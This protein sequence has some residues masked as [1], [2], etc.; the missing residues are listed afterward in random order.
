MKQTRT[1]ALAVAVLALAAIVPIAR[2]ATLVDEKFDYPNG[3]LAGR[4]GWTAHS[5]LG[6]QAVQVLDYAAR[7]VQGA[8]TAEDVNVAFAPQAPSA[9]T[10][11]GFTLRVPSLGGT[12]TLPTPDYF[13]HFRT[14]SNFNFRGRVHLAAAGPGQYSVGISVT[15][16]GTSPVVYW[17]APLD[18]DEHYRIVVSYSASAGAATLSVDPTSLASPSVAS[19]HPT[20]VGE[21]VDSYALR[22]SNLQTVHEHVDDLVVGTTFDDVARPCGSN[23]VRP[24]CVELRQ[25][26]WVG[27]TGTPI[28][29]NSVWG[30]LS[31]EHTP[32]SN[33][34]RYANLVLKRGVTTAWAIQNLPLFPLAAGA[35]PTRVEMA[36][37]DLGEIGVSSGIGAGPV[38]YLLTYDGGPRPTIP[39][40]PFLLGSFVPALRDAW[41]QDEEAIFPGPWVDPGAPE[42]VKGPGA[43]VPA[44]QAANQ[45]RDVRPVQ[46]A[47]DHCFAGATARSL[48]WLNR[49]YN[50]GIP[51]TAQEIYDDLVAAGVSQPGL[52]PQKGRSREEWIK[53]KDTYARSQTNNGIV[54]GAWDGGENLNAIPNVEESKEKFVDWLKRELKAGEDVELTYN[55]NGGAHIVTVLEVYEKDG[56]LYV[57]Y[58]DDEEQG[59][60]DEKKK[61]GDKEVKHAKLVKKAGGKYGFRTDDNTITW[62]LAESPVRKTDGVKDLGHACGAAQAVQTDFGNSTLGA[63]DFANGSELDGACSSYQENTLHLFFAGNLESNFNKLEVFIDCVGGGQ[64]RLRNDNPNVDFDGL[65]R[66]GDDGSGNGLRFD[67]GFEADYWL[68]VTGGDVGGGTYRMFANY[69]ELLTGGGGT[70]GYLGETIA[71]GDGTLSGGS[72]PHGIKVAIVNSNVGGVGVGCSG[73]TAGDVQTG[74][75]FAIPLSALGGPFHCA[76]VTAFVNGG[77]HDFVSNQVLASLP[78]GTCNLGEPRAVD[79]ATVAGDQYFTACT[80][81]V[82]VAADPGRAITATFEAFPNPSRGDVRFAL[83]LRRGEAATVGIYDVAGRL[84]RRLDVPPVEGPV[85]PVWDGRDFSGRRV[86]PGLYL[87]RVRAD[88]VDRTARVL[89]L[90]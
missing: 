57:T 11:A 84:V 61:A 66:M 64:N 29:A 46:E 86:P 9:T 62:G 90:R 60:T 78:P 1:T 4:P 13:A 36:D 73:S 85:A 76:R 77:A 68:S 8:S 69:A 35:G 53:R 51:R 50:L 65:N 22:Q 79:L 87:A 63:V 3:P 88:G 30:A 10:W 25:L 42:A 14:S 39:V 41:D 37:I 15:S 52:N 67:E 28:V 89:R 31:F 56:E 2:A 40:G 47:E 80:P 58:R 70:G 49:K 82:A 16:S 7:L 81:L 12:V 23:A 6:V 83:Q 26:S 27:P 72:N 71:G 33:V 43:A 59:T 18:F 19:A 74:I 44:Q 34:T 32:D 45:G 38:E 17:P 20:A 48:D 5:A 55:W 21:P 24:G 75:E 54:T